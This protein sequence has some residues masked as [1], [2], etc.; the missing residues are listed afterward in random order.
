MADN[1]QL[2]DWEDVEIDD[3]ED[4]DTDKVSGYEKFARKAIPAIP[5][6][7]E[8]P[9]R[10]VAAPAR[11]AISQ[12]I[13]D[14]FGFGAIP[15][16][17]RQVGE[18][19]GKAP[20][21]TQLLEQAGINV[22]SYK[23]PTPFKKDLEGGTYELD[24]KELAGGV[25]SAFSDPTTYIAPPVSRVAK[26]TGAVA[27]GLGKEVLKK[28]ARAFGD[29]SEEAVERYIKNPR[30]VK[31]SG[32]QITPFVQ[33]Y[34]EMLKDLERRIFEG[35]AESR[36]ALENV[37]FNRSE[38]ADAFQ[39]VKNEI[40]Q[41]SEGVIDPPTQARLN[42][43]D[44]ML[45]AYAPKPAKQVPSGY[46]DLTGKPATKSVAQGPEVLSGNRVKN[47]V[48]QLQRRSN[49]SSGPGDFLE[50]SDIDKNKIMSILNS[51]LKENP[52]YAEIMRGVSEDM[53]LLNRA[54][55]LGRTEGALENVLRNVGKTRETPANVLAEVDQRLGTD[56]RERLSNTLANR[57]FQM[58]SPNGARRVAAFSAAAA[59]ITAALSKDPATAALFQGTATG[60]GFLADKYGGKMAQAGIDA[61][62]FLPRKAQSIAA[63]AEARLPRDSKAFNML[64]KAADNSAKSLVITHHL[65]M[66]SDQEYRNLYNTEEG[67]Q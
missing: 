52:Q 23:I 19:P 22:P 12:T 65:L 21:G 49:F 50:V 56:F 36:K 2:D 15:A 64:K 27:G 9:E 57:Q 38:I 28:G 60:L 14:P 32:T 41:Q 20:S 35:S 18:D 67:Q 55:S 63:F 25:A 29:V 1:N 34:Q 5:K 37:K 66:N 54:T 43:I 42:A 53:D 33:Q 31:E 40:I 6:I 24:T 61:A 44:S 7:M 4:V 62:M 8:L 3:W 51:R 13:K 46:L 16:Y 48:Q 17:L 11:A 58:T 10:Y 45:E 59:P 47:L 30:G 39:Q 26:T